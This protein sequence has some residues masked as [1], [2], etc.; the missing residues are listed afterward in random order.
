MDVSGEAG[1]GRSRFGPAAD[2]LMMPAGVPAYRWSSDSAASAALTMEPAS[3]SCT[4]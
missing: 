1:A 2:L 3:R 4:R